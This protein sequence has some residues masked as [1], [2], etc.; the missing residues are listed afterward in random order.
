MSN[1]GAKL[2][3]LLER[4]RLSAADLSRLTKI[5]E[6]QI[7]KWINGKQTYVSAGDLEALCLALT[8]DIHEQAE[9]IRAHLLDERPETKAGKLID[10]RIL[11]EA[12][13]R[14]L[15]LDTPIYRVPLS[16]KL[17]RAFDVLMEESVADAD[18]RDTVLGIASILDRDVEQADEANSAVDAAGKQIVAAAAESAGAATLPPPP[19]GPVRYKVPRRSKKKR[20]GADD[21]A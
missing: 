6:A 5:S 8:T 7:S 20:P 2:A 21:A 12:G 18:V 17:Q 9:L 10:V 13:G 16:P 19:A 14:A 3:D 11:T 1:F 4:S 15:H